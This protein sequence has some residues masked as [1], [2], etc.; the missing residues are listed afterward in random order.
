MG[1]DKKEVVKEA[2]K[3]TIEKIEVKSSGLTSQELADL[4]IKKNS[5][6]NE[7]TLIA[8]SIDD[9]KIQREKAEANFKSLCEELN[10]KK[11]E[12][13]WINTEIGAQN[14]HLKNIKSAIEKERSEEIESLKTQT[15]RVTKAN[16]EYQKLIQECVTKREL[17]DSELH[18]IQSERAVHAAESQRLNK[19]MVDNESKLKYGL[20]D[21]EEQRAILDKDRQEFEEFKASLEPDLKRI[22]QIKNENQNFLNKLDSQM[23]SLKADRQ[24]FQNERESLYAQVEREKKRVLDYEKVIHEKEAELERKKQE[25]SDFELELRSREIDA[26][27]MMKR[28][29]MTHKVETAK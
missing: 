2:A 14:V 18:K 23:E 20:Q 19:A 4:Q 3:K 29:E 25:L 26:Q 6:L 5:E 21:L 11:R 13:D 8:Q 7:K 28:Y 22:S 16:A 24:S 12:I 27:K 9:L 1:R 17:L 15:E 10:L